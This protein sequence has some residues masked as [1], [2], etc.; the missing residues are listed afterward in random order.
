MKLNCYI[1]AYM[2]E[3]SL[4]MG[5]LLLDIFLS[6]G[7]FAQELPPRPISVTVSEAQSLNFGAFCTPSS[8]GS[9]VL[10]PD[11]TRSAAGDIVLI[12]LG[13]SFSPA[14][15]DIVANE[16]TIISILSGVGTESTIQ[17]MSGETMTLQVGDSEPASPFIITENPPA[18]SQVTVGATLI[19]GNNIDNPPGE[20][21][22][23]FTVTFVQQ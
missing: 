17:S 11:G 7:L 12:S 15:F 21:S 1:Q 23:T 3:C 4:I 13:Y 2:K 5:A 22:G 14:M 16:G 19:V 9:V 6:S 8:G 18:V 10:Y 20:Y